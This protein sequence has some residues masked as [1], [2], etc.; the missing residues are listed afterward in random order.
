MVRPYFYD[1]ETCGFH[2]MPVLLQ[3]ARDREDEVILYEIWHEPVYKTLALIEDMM[4]EGVIGFNLAFDQF[5]LCKLYTVW[6]LLDPNWLPVDHIDEIAHFEPLG[7]DGPCLKPTHCLDLMMYARKGPYQSTMDRK[8][9]CV[10]RVP[11]IMAKPLIEELESRVELNEI[12]FAKRKDKRAAKWAE[13]ACKN[14]ETGEIDPDFSNVMLKFRPSSSLKAIA[15]DMFGK[16]TLKFKDIELDHK[17]RPEEVGFAPFAL[18]VDPDGHWRKSWPAMIKE[19]IDHWRYRANAREYAKNDIVYT[20][21]LYYAWDMPALNDDDSVLCCMVAACRWRGYRIDRDK[22][23]ALKKAKAQAILDAPRTASRVRAWIWPDLSPAEIS[24]AKNSTKKTVLEEMQKWVNDDGTRHPAAIKAEAVILARRAEKEMEIYDKLL[25]AG[26]F[27]ASFIVIGALSSRM[28]GGDGDLNSQGIK[29]TKEVRRCFPLAWDSD[30][31]G[32]LGVDGFGHMT[33]TQRQFLAERRDK[34]NLDLSKY[35][36]DTSN[37]ILCGGDFESFEVTIA[38]AVWGDPKLHEDLQNG[39]SIHGIFGTF[40]YPHLT[41]EQI[42]SSKGMVMDYYNRCKSAVFAMLYGGEGYTLM[43]RLGVDI[44][45]ADK[46]HKEFADEY[47]SIRRQQDILA[48]KFCTI[49]QPKG[50]GTKV[51]WRDP[52]DYIESVFGDRRY[53]TVENT[54]TKILFE[55]SEKP[56]AA[57]NRYEERVKRY[58]IEQKVAG[59]V[60]SA[61]YGAAFNLQSGIKRAAGNHLIQAAGARVTKRTQTAIWEVQPKGIHPWLVQPM[62]VHDEIMCPTHAG[63]DSAV[64]EEVKRRVDN[65]VNA[66]KKTI[67]LLGMEWSIKLSSWADK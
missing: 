31:I 59:A 11:K 48:T 24:I 8:A 32:L 50:R 40:V 13:Y 16:P 35:H 29:R 49:S 47:S 6:Q 7:R 34:L 15:E 18:A 57:W 37:Y 27:H 1:T 23:L 12:Y 30:V 54:I 55:L 3:Y 67:P 46:A 66:F 28:S 62:N 63:A 44:E 36:P 17:Y 33:G 22:I 4:K 42:M 39:K 9:I 19:H 26:R 45:T 5:Q 56:P 10:R 52:D 41:Y 65:T 58:E 43:T 14:R 51:F 25:L 20:R 21:G 64:M 2:G 38:D 53:F 60:R 61:L